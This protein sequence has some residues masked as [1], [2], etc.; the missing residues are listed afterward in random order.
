MT[1]ESSLLARIV[2]I[3]KNDKEAALQE[4]EGDGTAACAAWIDW[5]VA[6]LRDLDAL[7]DDADDAAYALAMRYTALKATWIEYNT[8]LNYQLVHRGESDPN[9]MQLAGIVSRFLGHIEP[10]VDAK[11]VASIT[12]VLSNPVVG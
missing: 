7:V 9:L 2:D 3:I 1:S 12:R 10:H 4:I 5:L 11:A 8:L 6:S